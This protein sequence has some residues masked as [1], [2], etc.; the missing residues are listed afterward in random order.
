MNSPFTVEQFLNVF[1]DYN[2][3]VWPIQV[4]FIPF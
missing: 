3:S 2:E 4:V 1:K